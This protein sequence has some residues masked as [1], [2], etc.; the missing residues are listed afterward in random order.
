MKIIAI[1]FIFFFTTIIFSQNKPKE[2][3]AVR[4]SEAPKIDG[5]LNDPV[6]ENANIARDFVMFDPGNGD[7]E[8]DNQKTEVK[9]LY[10]DHAIYIGGSIYDSN[11]KNILRQFTER[12]NFGTSDILGLSLNPNNDG[13]NEFWFI[14]SAAGT[15]M[16]AQISPSNGEDFSW[17]EVWFSEISFD[18]KGWY[19]EIKIPYSAL[20]FSKNDIQSWG[21]NFFR[22]IES[23]K[24]LYSWNYIDKTTGNVPQYS[25]LLTGL[26]DI[27][28]PTRLG[29]SPFTTFIVDDFDG[30]TTTDYAFGLDL[31]YGITDNFTLFATLVP[32]FSQT[33]FDNVVLNLGP[34]EQVFSEQR[35]FFIEG[36]DL[37]EKGNLF[38]SRRIGNRPTGHSD[39][40]D[41][42]NENEEIID[43]PTEV[44]VI[45]A[46]KVTGRSKNGLGIGVLNAI[47]KKNQAT[48][49]DTINGETRKLITEP[50]AN[51]NV[52]VFDQEFNKNSSV[53]IVNT[54]VLREGHFRDANVT[55]LVFN[56]ANKPN[57]YKIGGNISTSIVSENGINTT[58]FSSNLDFRKTAGNVRYSVR[59]RFADDKYDKN[60]LGFQRQNNYNNFTG[61]IS[62]RIFEPTKRFNNFH[63]NLFIGHFRRYDP[64][65]NTGN[66]IELDISATNLK[67]L[68]YGFEIGSNI[69]ERID[70]FEPRTEGRF[71]VRNARFQLDGFISTDNR[72]KLA[73]HVNI[74]TSLRYDTDE[75][76][77]FIVVGPRFRAS[78]KL[79][80]SYSLLLDKRINEPGYV[81]TLDDDTI[82]FGVRENRQIENTVSGKYNFNDK[83]S[84]TLSFRHYWS[85]VTYEDQ[86]YSL[87]DDGS[88]IE[89]DYNEENDVNFNSWN[90]DLRYV[91]QFT[92]GSELVALYRN[93]ILNFDSESDLSFE[94]NISNLFDQPLGH[95]FSI[96]LIYYLDY[97]RMKSWIKK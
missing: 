93:S 37:L 52:L 25:G 54:N 23:E 36:A 77:Y 89:N 55:S 5:E 92:R 50:L 32:D 88:L 53:G 38:F 44:D 8:P 84:L 6:W 73:V 87:E 41:N 83:S 11:T 74:G 61:S 16:D 82:I 7:K 66:Y 33:G 75:R 95:S 79:Q 22:S 71:W 43:N 96:K 94:D 4:V 21:I 29:L 65:V 46:I 10:D 78:D 13:Q 15:Q 60:D 59:H 28:P 85:P 30:T 39:V 58:G 34:F 64:S 1:I 42:L 86:Y 62:Y 31:K 69:G 97:N 57:T 17:S 3:Q 67:Q 81:E 76:S 68:S 49:K 14:V 70:F 20:R 51:Y 48:I 56:L 80:F 27:N 91:W 19:V 12:D 2:I 72:K 47:T 35:Q 18:E 26:Q 40:E 9:I 90:F 45:N 63:A 24:Q